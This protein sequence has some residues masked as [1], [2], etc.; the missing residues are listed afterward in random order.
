MTNKFI[1]QL[2]QMDIN[3]NLYLNLVKR[4]ADLNGYDSNNLFFSNK[5][6]KK[7]MYKHN[8]KFTHFGQVNYNDFIIYNLLEFYNKVPNGTATKKRRN[9][10]SR[11]ENIKGDWKLNKFSP[12]NLAINILW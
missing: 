4:W 8:N 12:N 5:K 10:R 11:A 9:Y 7:L 1:E 6:N 2:K 3:P